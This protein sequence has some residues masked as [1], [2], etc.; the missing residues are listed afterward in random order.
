MPN[1]RKS[2][3]ALLLS[4]AMGVCLSAGM[5]AAQQPPRPPNP[6]A[7]AR[8]RTLEAQQ[9]VNDL[10]AEQKR[11][12]DKLIVDFG[13]K[14]EWKDTVPNLK[15][16][17][18]EFKAAE[19][20]ALI[21]M[22]NSPEYKKLLKEQQELT[23]KMDGFRTSRNA[24]EKTIIRT[25]TQLAEVG[26]KLKKMDGAAVAQDEKATDAKDKLTEA[27]KKM[28]DLEKEVDTALQS[29]PEYIALDQ[30][31]LQAEQQLQAAKD[32]ENA[33][34]QA[35]RTARPPAPTKAPRRAQRGD[36]DDPG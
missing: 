32:Q 26:T 31:V 27:Q 21:T 5:A 14:E 10:R 30:Q 34:R 6:A 20:A 23:A 9:V 24:D 17:D 36:F 16:A 29:D 3:L 4:L 11:I 22:R 15:K 7:E 8:K 13:E 19:R 1:V 33:A 12:K 18:K 25:G 2:R 28:K 35:Q